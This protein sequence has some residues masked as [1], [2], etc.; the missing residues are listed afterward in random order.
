MLS[1]GF[2]F[3]RNRGNINAYMRQILSAILLVVLSV[4]V[5][6]VSFTLQQVRQQENSL[7]LDIEHRSTILIDGFKS[8]ITSQ[9][10][11]KDTTG[12]QQTVTSVTSQERLAG[13]AVFDS[14]DK[15]LAISSNLPASFIL[16]QTESATAMDSAKSTGS[17]IE[18][19]NKKVYD[20]AVPLE[21]N[22][23]VVGSILVVQNA[24][25]IDSAISDIWKTN[26]IQLLAYSLLFSVLIFLILQWIIRLPLL[27]LT[28]S[29]KSARA[30]NTDHPLPLKHFFFQPLINEIAQMVTSLKDARFSASLEARL[31]QTKIDSPWTAQRLNEFSKDVLKSRKMFVVS[32]REPYIHSKHN[33]QISY[34][35]PASGMV[36]AIEPIMQACGGMWI[37]QASGNADKDT[38]DKNDNILVPPEEP[39]YTL[40][41]VWLTKQEEKGFYYGFSNE[42]I[43]PLCHMAHTRPIFRK[44]DYTEYKKVNGKFAETLLQQIKNTRAPVILI[45]DYHFALLPR[46]IKKSRPD[47]QIGIFWHIP[48]PHAESFRICPWRKELLDGMLG[49][50]VVGFHTQLDCNNFI[51]TVRHELES[52]IDLEQFA[53]QRDNH[54]SYVKPFPISI[55]YAEDNQH[56]ELANSSKL[57]EKMGVKTPF[58]GLGVDR[59][60]YTKGIL[61]RLRAVEYLLQTHPSYREQFTFI[62]IGAPTRS[63][64]PEYSDFATDVEKEVRRINDKF[65]TEHWHPIVFLKKHHSHA[66]LNE[67]YKAVNICVVTSLHDGMNLVA[68]EFVM[69]RADEKGVLILSQFAGASRELKEALIVNPYNTEETGEAIYQGLTMMQ[70]EQ[71]KRMKKL[72]ER[73]KNNNVYRWSADLLKTLVAIE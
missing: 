40:H 35:Q 71:I 21:D 55:P 43:W 1:D 72:R 42:G 12:I 64:I 23:A 8:A 39:S 7:T 58:I 24:S 17:F 5:V 63:T 69:A 34:L 6:V 30:G 15:L 51:D 54:L 52:L 2:A 57:L 38:V 13:L 11:Q 68:K 36:T 16:K 59:L 66:E 26:L 33:G 27:A 67:L 14:K 46:I 62:Q 29:L 10:I 25:Y 61:E 53:V 9:L 31:R 60:D 41:R 37:A 56:D 4:C 47:A 48:W 44:E 3:S 28:E 70:S 19:N 65:K 20:F 22:G 50:D 73:V 49:A 32:N 18:L 45:Q